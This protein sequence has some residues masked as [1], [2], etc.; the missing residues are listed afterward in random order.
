MF[1][2]VVYYFLLSARSSGV[3]KSDCFF[4]PLDLLVLPKLQDHNKLIDILS[5]KT[6]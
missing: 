2:F 1:L 3:T 5:C 4:T 6:N